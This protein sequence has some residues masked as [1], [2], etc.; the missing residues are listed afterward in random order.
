MRKLLEHGSET[1]CIAFRHKTSFPMELKTVILTRI[2][3]HLYM[4]CKPFKKLALEGL[5]SPFC[6]VKKLA[7]EGLASPS[8]RFGFFLMKF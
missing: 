4:Q 2:L 3:G 7:L 6:F 5:A 1:A 8:Y